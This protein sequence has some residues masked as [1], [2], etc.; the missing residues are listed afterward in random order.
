MPRLPAWERVLQ[1]QAAE[2]ADETCE[3]RPAKPA[4]TSVFETTDVGLVDTAQELELTLRESEEPALPA[5]QFADLL[6]PL[7][8]SGVMVR[9]IERFPGHP[10][11]MTARD[12]LELIKAV[13]HARAETNPS[14]L[15]QLECI[16]MATRGAG[17]WKGVN[18]TVTVLTHA[19]GRAEAAPTNNAVRLG[20]DARL[21]AR[22][23]AASPLRANSASARAN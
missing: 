11:T 23:R 12:H 3:A 20:S 8:R 16:R 17:G 4:Q 18:R 2:R 15:M 22:G 19:V 21:D 1:S 5:N 14:F 7:P 10:P 9:D 6:Q 13:S